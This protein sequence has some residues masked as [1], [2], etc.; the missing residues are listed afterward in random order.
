MIT[1]ALSPKVTPTGLD[2]STVNVSFGS[3]A[4]SPTIGIEIVAVWLPAAK[5]AVP[6]DA[7]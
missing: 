3:T 5:V 4:A 2:R 6:E 7:V 1:A